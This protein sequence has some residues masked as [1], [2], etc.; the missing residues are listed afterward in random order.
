MQRN[1]CK[2]KVQRKYYAE[3]KMPEIQ[4]KRGLQAGPTTAYVQTCVY[5]F[6]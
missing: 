5:S 2:K 1:K 6:F 3:K 4:Q